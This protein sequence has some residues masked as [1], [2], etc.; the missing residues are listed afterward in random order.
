MVSAADLTKIDRNLLRE[1]HY[2]GK[3]QYALAVLGPDARFKVWLVLDGDALYADK[4]GNGDLTEPGK[5]FAGEKVQY[6]RGTVFKVGDIS[7]GAERY[8]NLEVRIESLKESAATYEEWPAFQKLIA[9]HPEATGYTLSVDVPLRRP[10]PDGKGGQVTRLR[11]Y[12]SLADANGFLQFADRPEAAPV[13]HFGGPWSIWPREA[14]KLVLGRSD[15]FDTLIG[16][17][18]IGPGT[19]ALI[20]YHTIEDKPSIFVPKEARP[21]LQLLL[22]GKDRKHVTTDVVLEN[23]C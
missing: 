8:T 3:P 17:P 21:V 18:G 7:V 12:V 22:P 2:R 9:A 15:E 11:H 19:L 1:P 20:L 14:Q 16:T 10:L 5:K 13:I 4:S 6:F 23:R